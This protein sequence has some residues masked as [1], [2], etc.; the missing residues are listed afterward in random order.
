MAL[1][2]TQAQLLDELLSRYE[3]RVA[4]AFLAAV[5]DIRNAADFQRLVTALTNRDMQSAIDALHLDP[6]AFNDLARKIEDA[7]TTSGKLASDQAS[8]VTTPTGANVVVRFD[9]R[10]SRAEA[11]L[12]SQSADLVTA[13]IGD[14]KLAIRNAIAAGQAAGQ[15][16]T[17]TALELVGRMSRVTGQREG[18][19]IGLSSPQEAYLRSARAE[20]ASDAPDLL[21]NYLT[22]SRRDRRFDRSVAKAIREGTALPDDIAEKAAT[23]YQRSLL[24][25]RADIIGRTETLTSLNAAQHESAMQLVE[26]GLFGASEVTRAWH[27]THDARTRDT[28]VVLS[29][30]VVG[31]HEPFRSPS[32][33]LM[34][35][36]GD[37]S[38][39]APPAETIGC[40]CVAITKLPKLI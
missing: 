2:P 25:L 38:L 4:E 40:R 37:T 32:G 6:A 24:K 18:G 22:R 9:V 31:L 10:N 8:P 15:N 27:A 39:G 7:Y 33:A 26:R 35:F 17:Q 1:S 16:P 19:I 36:P 3:R 23:G 30:Q 34:L 28:H 13:L 21:R 5:R 29:G 11:W 14:Q 20:L 12:R